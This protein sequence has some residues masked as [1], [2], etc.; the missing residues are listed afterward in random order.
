MMIFDP[1]TGAIM[2]DKAFHDQ[3]GRPG[4]DLSERTWP[5]GWSGSA[6]PHGVV[7]SR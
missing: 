3:A 7:F 4:F 5:H 2:I 6:I 1:A